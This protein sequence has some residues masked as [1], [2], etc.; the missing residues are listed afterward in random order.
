MVVSPK[1]IRGFGLPGFIEEEDRGDGSCCTDCLDDR[2]G[3]ENLVRIVDLFID[4]FD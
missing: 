2:V 1:G 3:E 4:E